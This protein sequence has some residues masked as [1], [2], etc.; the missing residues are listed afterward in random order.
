M[1]VSAKSGVN[2]GVLFDEIALKLLETHAKTAT[3]SRYLA[4]PTQNLSFNNDQSM[5]GPGSG[6][7]KIVDL[8]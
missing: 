7:I 1:E 6:G 3:K 8:T 2:I 4:D 5:D